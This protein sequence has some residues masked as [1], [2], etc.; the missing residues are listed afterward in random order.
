[1]TGV[2]SS[3]RSGA[4]RLRFH[5]TSLIGDDVMTIVPAG[6]KVYLALH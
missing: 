2:A 4:I 5:G 1:M 3:R 6:V